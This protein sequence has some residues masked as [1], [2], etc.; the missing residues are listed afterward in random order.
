MKG[1]RGGSSAQHSFCVFE[2]S[3][4]IPGSLV[5]EQLGPKSVDLAI[6]FNTDQHEPLYRAISALTGKTPR[7]KDGDVI[8][9][10]VEISQP[11]KTGL[12]NAVKN[13]A[14]GVALT[15]L[16]V[17]DRTPERLASLLPPNAMVVD[18]YALLDALREV[19]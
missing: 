2:L 13:A 6:P 19:S 4:R 17:D 16:A 3:R 1:L 5:E 12:R 8:A 14:A 10:E 9:I 11:S 18:V 7:L 15:V